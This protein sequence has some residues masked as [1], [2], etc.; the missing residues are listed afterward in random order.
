[1]QRERELKFTHSRDLLNPDK[2]NRRRHRRQSWRSNPCKQSGTQRAGGI[3]S[4]SSFHS[5]VSPSDSSI[6]GVTVH[7]KLEPHI[8][9]GLVWLIMIFKS[10]KTIDKFPLKCWTFFLF[11]FCNFRKLAEEKPCAFPNYY[12]D[13]N[14]RLT[15]FFSLSN[16][17]WPFSCMHTFRQMAETVLHPSLLVLSNQRKPPL[18]HWWS[19][20]WEQLGLHFPTQWHSTLCLIENLL[21]LLSH[22]ETQQ[23]WMSQC[24][25][26]TAN[27]AQSALTP[28]TELM[29][30]CASP[31]NL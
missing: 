8:G 17:K 11:F 26:W 20:L 6:L 10:W 1:M 13:A 25:P 7:S 31:C 14:I 4:C 28:S 29:P 12:S 21:D 19:S 15:D 27:E 22:P 18:L 5:S 23:Q 3:T 9:P 24:I 30:R 2:E 16:G